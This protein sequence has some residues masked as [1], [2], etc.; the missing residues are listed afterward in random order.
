MLLLF[1]LLCGLLGA[2]VTSPY[3]GLLPPSFPRAGRQLL[4]S[5]LLPG[6]CL[7]QGWPGAVSPSP[8]YTSRAEAQPGQVV[9]TQPWGT[10]EVQLSPAEQPRSIQSKA[11]DLLITMVKSILPYISPGSVQPVLFKA[12]ELYL[13]C[14]SFS[15]GQRGR[16]SS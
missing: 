16:G 9:G 3:P 14:S 4:C 15:I 1:F 10:C 2:I 8:C 7:L 6:L 5:P 11:Y 13:F 12:S